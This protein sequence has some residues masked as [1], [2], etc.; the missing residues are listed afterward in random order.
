MLDYFNLESTIMNKKENVIQTRSFEF[1]IE[2][3]KFYKHCLDSNE[4]L[5][6]KQLVRS[7]TS[8]GANVEEASAAQ[9]K[10]DF[11]AKMSISSK[12]ARETRYWLRLFSKSGIIEYN[13]AFLLKEI[14]EII[15]ILTAIVKTAQQNI[16]T[17]KD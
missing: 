4:Y 5:L 17:K 13:Y 15:N 6:S 7:G 3:I 14:D 16:K 10:K 1:A 8:I 9:S 2:I 11:I 12:E